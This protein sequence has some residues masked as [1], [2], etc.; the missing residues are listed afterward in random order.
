MT[1]LTQ[2]MLAGGNAFVFSI[3]LTPIVRDVFRSYNVVDRPGRRKVHAYPIP[4]IGGISIAIAYVIALNSLRGQAAGFPLHWLQTILSGTAI[5]FVTGLLDDFLNLKPVVKLAGQIAAAIVAFLSGLSIDHIGA[6]MLPT[7]LSLVIT[8][9]WLLLTT[10]ALNLID[11][12]DG[13]CGGVALWATLAFFAVGLT[14]GNATLAFTALPLA[15]ILLGFLAFNFNPATVFLGDSGALTIGFL[16][17]CFGI[18]WTG[19]QITAG[20]LVVPI[21]ALSVPMLDL[22]LSIVRRSLKNQPIFSADRGHIH[23]ML[24]DRGLSVRR[25]ALILYAVGIAGGLSGLAL[26]HTG[27]HPGLRLPIVAALVFA[28]LAGIRELRYPEF[29]VTGRLLFRG[30]F[31]K[32]FAARL[33]VK[34]LARALERAETGEEW[35]RL[36]IAAAREWDCI[37]LQWTG[38]GTF[39]EELLASRKASWSFVIEVSETDSIQL[40]GDVKTACPPNPGDLSALLTRTFQRGPRSVAHTAVS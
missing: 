25:A 1:N 29:E 23:H 31:Q 4:R 17:G 9:F 16:L 34:Q 15:A 37:R 26:S 22:G 30:E 7:W 3:A 39:R 11:G 6:T 38:P 13:L 8:V 2:L 35:W 33:R 19:H 36:L 14:H 32:I 12:L 20:G 5:I 40:E 24:L 10:N 21:L 28:T 27:S 18:I